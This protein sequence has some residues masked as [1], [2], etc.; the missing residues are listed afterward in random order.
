MILKETIIIV[1]I[2]H[3]KLNAKEIRI[4]CIDQFHIRRQL[5]MFGV[6]CL[7]CDEQCE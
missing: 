3:R 7:I 2:N 4:V 5:S 1:D 6:K